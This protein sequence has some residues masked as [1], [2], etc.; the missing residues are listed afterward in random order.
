VH[1]AI[2]SGLAAVAATVQQA[3]SLPSAG[4]AT[5]DIAGVRLGMTPDAVRRALVAA[6][7]RIDH[8]DATNSFQ[9]NVVVE[10]AHAQGR[11]PA[12]YGK[13]TSV[14]R[15]W[16][17]GPHGEALTVDFDQWPG[18]AFVGAVDLAIKP[19]RQTL[20]DLQAQI[21][22]KYGM[23]SL[24][25]DS[26]SFQWC[27]P[28]ERGCDRISVPQLPTLQVGYATPYTVRLRENGQVAS[29]LNAAFKAS[30]EARAPKTER[31]AF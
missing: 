28:G 12:T 3:P 10:A 11:M 27:T 20:A 24:K 9:D 7:Y 29:Q 26:L 6:G 2:V 5:F 8:T 17:N 25:T 30:V 1:L 13:S 14:G 19:E 23:P 22:G 18:G 21:E 31:S 16:A 15:I 4:P